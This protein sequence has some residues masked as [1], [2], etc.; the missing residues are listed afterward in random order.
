[1]R[2]YSDIQ[3]ASP[4][5]IRAWMDQS[6][7]AWNA[8]LEAETRV[9][10]ARI[11]PMP[12][13]VAFAAKAPEVAAQV[14]QRTAQIFDEIKQA[15]PNLRGVYNDWNFGRVFRE[16]L[17]PL[18]VDKDISPSKLRS[19]AW[20]TAMESMSDVAAKV[21]AKIGDMV[22]ARVV[23]AHGAFITITGR[24][25]R[26]G[27][28]QLEQNQILNVS[29]KGKLFNQW[30]AR[31]YVNGK[32]TSEAEYKR[33]TEDSAMRV[34]VSEPLYRELVATESDTQPDAEGMRAKGLSEEQIR[35]VE[36]LRSPTAASS[37]WVSLPLDAGSDA[38]FR[39]PSRGALASQEDYLSDSGGGYS[40]EER[41]A[42][43]E[44]LKEVKAL[45]GR[46]EAK[47]IK[48]R[49]GGVL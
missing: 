11:V 38:W 46:K 40:R 16:T 44:M 21:A 5:D 4:P 25:P 45:L 42:R 37:G 9:A 14:M 34:V 12:L 18:V 15:Y 35:F 47:Y 36:A 2:I 30:P 48:A 17:Y 10:L 31:I 13:A 8:A 23:E 32:F 24:H 6:E 27:A 39:D 29:S 7:D 26:L 49:S 19:Y 41:E 22:D 1:M 28:I 20:A 3:A 33:L 43:K